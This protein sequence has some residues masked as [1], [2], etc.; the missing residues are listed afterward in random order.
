MGLR[1]FLKHPSTGLLTLYKHARSL[2]VLFDRVFQ[3]FPSVRSATWSQVRERDGERWRL[4]RAT[5]RS[6]LKAAVA[7]YAIT[8]SEGRERGAS[9]K[10]R[11]RSVVHVLVYGKMA[12]WA[13]LW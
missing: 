8:V 2:S 12:G 9:C 11:Q 5:R 3:N 1:E 13:Q 10:I 7:S 4:V 6:R